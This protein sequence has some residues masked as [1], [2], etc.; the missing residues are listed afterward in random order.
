ML[1]LRDMLEILSLKYSSV[2]PAQINTQSYTKPL[3]QEYISELI[4]KELFP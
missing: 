2:E 3:L 4:S 1:L